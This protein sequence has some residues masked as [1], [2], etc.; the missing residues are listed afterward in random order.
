MLDRADHTAL[1]QRDLCVLQVTQARD[2][3]PMN[4]VD[5][6]SRFDL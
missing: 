6:Q 2:L 5:P 3:S 4:D 1:A